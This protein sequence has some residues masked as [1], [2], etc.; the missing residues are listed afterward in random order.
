MI[1]E[2][3]RLTKPCIK[4]NEVLRGVVCA[5]KNGALCK[6][7]NTKKEEDPGENP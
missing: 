4:S 6:L 5:Y 1:A 7:K 2:F 3:T